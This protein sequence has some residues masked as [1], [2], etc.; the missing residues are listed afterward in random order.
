VTTVAF[1]DSPSVAV[2]EVLLDGFE[3]GIR[4]AGAWHLA[5]HLDAAPQLDAT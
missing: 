3:L 4:F 2:G 5:D 1:D